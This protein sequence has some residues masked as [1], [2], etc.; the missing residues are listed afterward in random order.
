MYLDSVV[1]FYEKEI[2]N[3]NIT[4]AFVKVYLLCEMWSDQLFFDRKAD[5]D[6]IR[7]IHA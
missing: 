5:L 6:E 2:Y 3:I 7:T 4:F 1:N